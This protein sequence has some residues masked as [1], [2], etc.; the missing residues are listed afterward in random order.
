[1][2]FKLSTTENNYCSDYW[3]EQK[4]YKDL[5][6]KFKLSS[7]GLHGYQTWELV[8]SEVIVELKSLKELIALVEKF[9][10]II[11]KNGA[12]LEIYDGYRE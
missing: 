10:E 11:I 5:G 3:N 8:D 9:G 6:F 1:M 7:L 4:K 2:K 12:E